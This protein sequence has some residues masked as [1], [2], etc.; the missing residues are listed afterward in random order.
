MVYPPSARNT[1]NLDPETTN[2][3]QLSF[4]LRNNNKIGV[5]HIIAKRCLLFW[6]MCP[7]HRV[8]NG[9]IM[10]KSLSLRLYYN[11]TTLIST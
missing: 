1:T 6:A 9:K 11:G 3:E 2:A 10:T 7:N 4:F 8:K 5:S